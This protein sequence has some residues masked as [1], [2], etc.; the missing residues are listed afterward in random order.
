MCDVKTIPD[1]AMT[2]GK[3]KDISGTTDRTENGDAAAGSCVMT[4]A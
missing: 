4:I 3:H 1:A 2:A